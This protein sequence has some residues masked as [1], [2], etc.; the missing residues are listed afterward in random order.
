MKLGDSFQRPTKRELQCVH[1]TLGIASGARGAL[2]AITLA[3]NHSPHSAS[4][5]SRGGAR[6]APSVNTSI[7]TTCPRCP[8]ANSSARQTPSAPTPSAHSATSPTSKNPSL[9]SGSP[10]GSASMD[11]SA[12]QSMSRK[13]PVPIT[14]LVFALMAPIVNS[15]TPSSSS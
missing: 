2:T 9:A 15:D 11:P 8:P 1:F 6:K 10:G 13:Q 4:I 12:A 3:I 14:W 7:N 5:G